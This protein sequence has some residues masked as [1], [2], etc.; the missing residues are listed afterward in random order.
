MSDANPQW[1]SYTRLVQ[2]ASTFSSTEP[3]GVFNEFIAFARQYFSPSLTTEPG[4]VEWLSAANRQADLVPLEILVKDW[5]PYVYHAR[6]DEVSWCLPQGRAVQP[7]YDEYISHCRQNLVNALIAP[8]SSLKNLLHYAGQCPELPDPSGFIFHL[9]RC[10]ST[11][12]SG[13]LA[14]LENCSV[15]SESPL[16]TEILLAKNIGCDEKKSLL[17]LLLHLQGLHFQG[18]PSPKQP[19]VIVKWNAWDIFYW[20][21]IR[22]VWPHVP[23][24]FLTRDPVEILASHA[25]SAGRHMGF[26]PA[27]TVLHPLFAP[28]QSSEGLLQQR[29]A[30]LELLMQKMHTHSVAKGVRTLDY[31]V[32]NPSVIVSICN[33]FGIAVGGEH[34]EVFIE[35]FSRNSK[36]PEVLF[37]ADGDSKRRFL[38]LDQVATITQALTPVYR[39]L[40]A[41]CAT[42]GYL[43][44]NY[45]DDLSCWVVS[46]PSGVHSRSSCIPSPPRSTKP[47]R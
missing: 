28:D 3:A 23:V 45:A 14:Q 6:T 10:G 42:A 29:V 41:A 22:E 40:S 33:H 21:L 11:L 18:R 38:P 35:R 9:S 17:R 44:A 12:V 13:C 2:A 24:L 16:L 34:I 43:N 15:L 20:D 47:R 19:H 30:V 25:K 4:V 46:R 36:Q 7:V 31:S 26:D 39:D 27:L 37:Q 1:Q 32:L 8:R 5:I